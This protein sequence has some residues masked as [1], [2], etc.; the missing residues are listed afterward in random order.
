MWKEP[1]SVTA[2]PD[3][4]EYARM[5]KERAPGLTDR[6]R[7]VCVQVLRGLTSEGIALTLG[8][9]INTVLTYRKR[10]YSRLCIGSQNELMRLVA[11]GPQ[12]AA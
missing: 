5:L 2:P 6:E 9:S 11:F 8:I 7:E 3:S 4:E 12:L 1:A 10:A